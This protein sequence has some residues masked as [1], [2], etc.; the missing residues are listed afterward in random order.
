MHRGTIRA[1]AAYSQSHKNH[2]T[3]T[4]HQKTKNDYNTKANHKN[5]SRNRIGGSRIRIAA[6]LVLRSCSFC[7]YVTAL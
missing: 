2:H 1:L 5:K 6:M 7:R 3:N 4:N